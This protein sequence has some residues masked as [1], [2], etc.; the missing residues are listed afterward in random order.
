MTTVYPS[1]CTTTLTL[2]RTQNFWNAFNALADE[3]GKHADSH[4]RLVRG[5][6]TAIDIQKLVV[7]QGKIVIDKNQVPPML[8]V[9]GIVWWT[10]AMCI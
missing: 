4:G 7:M 6:E 9:G 10:N 1:S 3:P 8:A 5:F 2:L